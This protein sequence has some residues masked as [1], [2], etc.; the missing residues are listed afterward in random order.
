MKRRVMSHIINYTRL[1]RNV[2]ISEKQADVFIEVMTGVIKE[3]ALATKIDLNLTEANLRGE[4]KD[5][6]LRL[7]QK[8][9]VV[10]IS[11]TGVASGIVVFLM[12]YYL[13]SEI[14]FF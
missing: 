2:G 13:S 5:L 3:G 4:F 10:I 8:L 7:L 11:S 6:E 1:M 12:K 9:S 14:A